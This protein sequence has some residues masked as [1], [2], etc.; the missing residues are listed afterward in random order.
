MVKGKNPMTDI[1]AVI[2]AMNFNSW[3]SMRM[4]AKLPD[5]F[6]QADILKAAREIVEEDTQPFHG[7][8]R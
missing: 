6:T 4:L 7:A 5:T 3:H 1:I 8:K 2:T